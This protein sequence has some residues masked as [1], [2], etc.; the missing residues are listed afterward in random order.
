MWRKNTLAVAAGAGGMLLAVLGCVF[1][2]AV[3][4]F[5]WFRL[6]DRRD[7]YGVV[8]AE[9]E[10]CLLG[11]LTFFAAPLAT[12]MLADALRFC[13]AAYLLEFGLFAALGLF[14]GRLLPQV[15]GHHH[16]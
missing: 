3:G 7:P 15:E 11:G 9:L 12:A 5:L 2:W 13:I 8:H 1:W 10:I 14:E 16:H 6:K 4:L